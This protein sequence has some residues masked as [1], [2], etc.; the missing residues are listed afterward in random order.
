MKK[1]EL[2]LFLSLLPSIVLFFSSCQPIVKDDKD[3]SERYY[4]NRQVSGEKDAIQ[5]SVATTAND[6][7]AEKREQFRVESNKKNEEYEILINDLKADIK[8]SGKKSDML[9]E[10]R[11]YILD[12]KNKYLKK[13]IDSFDRAKIDWETFRLEIKGD[14]EKLGHDLKVL[15]IEK[16]DKTS[17]SK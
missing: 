5:D 17:V 7:L 10:K 2:T 8:K 15:E 11:I 1:T 6:I 13:R 14:L 12:Q 3:L 9:F 16:T 4:V